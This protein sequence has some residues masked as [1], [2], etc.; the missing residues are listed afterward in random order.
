MQRLHSFSSAAGNSSSPC[1][2]RA[3]EVFAGAHRL[4]NCRS[5]PP[6][7]HQ[8]AK[9]GYTPYR[10]PADRYPEQRPTDTGEENSLPH[11]E[12]MQMPVP[13]ILRRRQVLKV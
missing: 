11:E 13:Y 5:P 1:N 2:A 9:A 6:P 7:A 12:Q 10:P 4:V 3:C 8:T